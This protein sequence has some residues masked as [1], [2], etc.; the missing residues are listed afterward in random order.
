MSDRD[1]S[2]ALWLGLYLLSKRD[3]AA[4][5]QEWQRETRLPT[6]YTG[7]QVQQVMSVMQQGYDRIWIVQYADGYLE[8]QR[9]AA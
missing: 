4:D 6:T 7:W 5:F 3:N 8:S 9:W 1:N 2:H